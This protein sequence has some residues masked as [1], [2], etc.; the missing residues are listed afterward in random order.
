GLGWALNAGGNISRTVKGIPD[1]AFGATS[2]YLNHR[3]D[4]EGFSQY[5][6]VTYYH[7]FNN[8]EIDFEQDIFYFAFG[9]YSGK[10]V[11]TKD[12]KVSFV[13]ASNLDISF[14]MSNN[15]FV[16]WQVR[17][18]KGNT[19]Y[20]REVERTVAEP[21]FNSRSQTS[22]RIHDSAWHLSEIVTFRGRSIKFSYQSYN[23]DFFRRSMQTASYFVSG[24][25]S[26][27]ACRPNRVENS[28]VEYNVRGKQ[29]SGIAF[30]EGVVSIVNE[31]D[32]E[33]SPVGR[34]KSI[35]VRNN[36][37][38]II[39]S[40][41]LVHDYFFSMLSNLAMSL[42]PQI[43]NAT[44]TKRLRLIKVL[45]TTSFPNLVHMFNYEGNSLPHLFSQA[46][47]HWGYYNGV[48]NQS[49][50]P[51]YMRF[52]QANA[53][54]LVSP[55]YA[56]YGCLKKITFP[57]G[58]SITYEMESNTSMVT[59]KDYNDFFA[60]L[61]I[62]TN[63]PKYSVTVNQNIRRATLRVEPQLSPA[64]SIK[65]FS[66][67]V[68]LPTPINC[69][70]RSKDCMGTVDVTLYSANI[71]HFVSLTS[72]S[73]ASG[74][75]EGRIG[76]RAGEV[77]QLSIDGPSS[78]IQG[79]SAAVVG[80][81]NPPMVDESRRIAINVGGLRV[82]EIV[83]DFLPHKER[84]NFLYEMPE[85]AEASGV[86]ASFPKYDYL[87]IK[88]TDKIDMRGNR[89]VFPCLK[90]E[91]RSVSQIPL[92]S[93]GAYFG[94]ANVKEIKDVDNRQIKTDYAF[95]TAL[96]YPDIVSYT[97]P[98]GILESRET[99]RGLPKAETNYAHTSKGI[100]KSKEVLYKY[101]RLVPYTDLNYYFACTQFNTAGCSKVFLFRY[102]NASSWN[103]LREVTEINYEPVSGKSIQKIRKIDHN[104]N[105]LLPI[106]E[107]ININGNSETT[108]YFYP[109]NA[110]ALSPTR[111]ASASINLLL[112]KHRI[113]DPLMVRKKI[114]GVMVEEDRMQFLVRNQ[115]PVVVA[116]ERLLNG[117]A[118]QKE[119]DILLHDPNHNIIEQKPR[120]GPLETFQWGYGLR[121]VTASVTNAKSAE[122]A[123]TSFEAGDK[124]GWIFSGT[125]IFSQ[126]AKTGSSYYNLSRGSISKTNIPANS[127]RPF[128]ISFWAR[129][130][131]GSVFWTFMG[132]SEILSTQWTLIE[133][134]ITGNTVQ[135][136]GS[137]IWIDELRL[138]PK[139]AQMVTFTHEPLVGITSMTDQRNQ[140]T[141]FEYDAWGRL[142]AVRDA[143]R[144]VLEHAAYHY[145]TGL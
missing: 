22:N 125:P 96:E 46:Q 62:D 94:Y 57:T 104:S 17:D 70:G 6:T 28:W 12:R 140:T 43:Q 52:R 54:R 121:H 20:F 103:P 35:T 78:Q 45:E 5:Q 123:Y 15:R 133:R 7:R 53:N 80:H 14:T 67:T 76:L 48:F 31:R 60:P 144:N 2:G 139:D 44:P 59:L 126:L 132:K 106:R 1:E 84:V 74:Q 120:N 51:Q 30:D 72:A 4:P 42:P 81:M 47:D 64:D 143:D 119:L 11:L 68:N 129:R 87:I 131:T 135:I 113:E 114:N 40:F 145:Q 122:V 77:Y 26:T 105:Y 124:G 83:K 99:S 25:S 88:E 55:T 69:D 75:I 61:A 29:L 101:E 66:Y 137:D 110:S 109:F 73:I 39:K 50:L 118:S 58:G 19:Y 18:P 112:Q 23:H 98:F 116:V 24:E 93:S 141:Y 134:E 95:Y 33:D 111:A 91:L 21:W 34:L 56:K 128:K 92:G 138:H 16:E 85:S 97:F 63:L 90:F 38:R 71:R 136:I 100:K 27:G 82:R 107:E 13:N 3:H 49:L 117:G 8:G 79:V 108:E 37:N 142:G 86:L 65:W 127:S 10:F 41:E 36:N 102:E 115:L 32:R 89:H 9:S 130:G